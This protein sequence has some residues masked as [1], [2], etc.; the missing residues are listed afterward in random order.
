MKA[1]MSALLIH[2]EKRVLPDGAI[3]EMVI[4]KLPKPLPGSRRACKYRLYFGRNGKRLVGFDNERGKG[5][6]RHLDG[7]EKP[8]SY[9]SVEALMRDFLLEVYRRMPE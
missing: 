4:W 6:H 9:T 3:I 5:D 1:N 7:D 2:R 8:Y